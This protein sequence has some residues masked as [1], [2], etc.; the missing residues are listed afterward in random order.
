MGKRKQPKPDTLTTVTTEVE[1]DHYRIKNW[2]AKE[3]SPILGPHAMHLYNIYCA[4]ANREL[5]NKWFFSIRTLEEFTLMHHNT[6]IMNNWLLE[7]CGLI[8]VNPGDDTY[9]NE[10]V[11]LPPPHVTDEIRASIIAA[12][13]AES[14][15]GKNWR[16]FKAN[17]LERVQKWKPLHEYGKVSQ[18]KKIQIAA[19]QPEPFTNGNGHHAASTDL[20]SQAELVV[21]LMKYFEQE[22]LTEKAAMNMITQYG[23]AAVVQQ[24]SWIDGRQSDTPLRTLRAALKGNWKEPKAV[25]KPE[26]KAFWDDGLHEVGPDGLVRPKQQVRDKVSCNKLNPDLGI[27]T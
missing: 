13:K 10:Y 18:F 3:W 12:L 17:V 26:P 2:V 21:G 24:M 19:G 20:P 1:E 8:R 25:G 15:V 23:V 6:I 11:I 4:A 27:E 14:D 9:A 5:G 22:E 7:L 16:A